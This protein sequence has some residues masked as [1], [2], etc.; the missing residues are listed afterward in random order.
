[1]F[2]CFSSLKPTASMLIRRECPETQ[3]CEDKRL[4]YETTSS[5]DKDGCRTFSDPDC[6]P[7]LSFSVDFVLHWWRVPVRWEDG[8]YGPPVWCRLWE[9]Q[10]CSIS[11]RAAISGVF[12]PRYGLAKM[13]HSAC[14]DTSLCSPSPSSPNLSIEFTGLCQHLESIA[15]WNGRSK[16]K[17]RLKE[18]Q[19]CNRI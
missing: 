19:I 4:I 6:F 10:N 7:N 3:S 16:A 8:L 5:P 12:H 14:Q 17:T 1:M 15:H 11:N 9:Q 2:S 18:M 13:A